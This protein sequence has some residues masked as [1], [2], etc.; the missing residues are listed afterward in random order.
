MTMAEMAGLGSRYQSDWIN[1]SR[2]HHDHH[3]WFPLSKARIGDSDTLLAFPV[4]TLH[5]DVR[6]IASLFNYRTLSLQ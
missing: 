4:E 3:L 5:F 2:N 6:D 1:H